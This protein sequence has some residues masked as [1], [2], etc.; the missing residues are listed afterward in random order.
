MVWVL[1][2]QAVPQRAGLKELPAEQCEVFNTV[3]VRNGEN[4]C[5]FLMWCQRTMHVRRS[6]FPEAHW[7]IIPVFYPAVS[8]CST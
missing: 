3:I 8:Y 1:W 5:A 4:R 7:R 2:P 6:A